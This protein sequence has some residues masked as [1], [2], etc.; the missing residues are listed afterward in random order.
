MNILVFK[1][2]LYGDMAID[3]I[4]NIKSAID[5]VNPITNLRRKINLLPNQCKIN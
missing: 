4:I 3:L 5:K 1:D 2:F